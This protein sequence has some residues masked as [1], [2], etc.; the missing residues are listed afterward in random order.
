MQ[1]T[2]MKA[3]I[4]ALRLR[5]L[6]LSLSG[7]VTATGIAGFY[8]TFDPLTFI[9]MF[10]MVALL[11]IDSNFAD[12][13]GDLAHGADNEDRIGPVRGLQRGDIT[14]PQMKRAIIICSIAALAFA[15]ALLLTSF[16]EGQTGYLVL[17]IVL[18]GICVAGALLYTMGSHPYGYHMLGDAAVFV[19]FG[20]ISVIGGAFL[21][22]ARAG[23][24]TFVLA[25]VLPAIAVGCLSTGVLNLNNMRDIETDEAAGKM[26]LA[27]KLG[28]EKARWYHMVLIVVGMAGFLSFPIATG[29]HKALAYLFVL[30]FI[31]L[32]KQLVGVM[33]VENRA[34]YDRF[35]KPLSMTTFA[36]SI[37]FALCMTFLA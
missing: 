18:A 17:F 10:V 28:P 4:D 6:P 2:K 27:V 32:A 11:Q 7:V 29:V 9:L 35:M 5:T 19:F 36:I 34:D 26:T 16:G 20:L 30:G 12:E 24:P 14:A 13:Y 23:H 8:H 25:T 22:T 33:A 37:A 3:W 15:L 1:D 31:P 21:Y